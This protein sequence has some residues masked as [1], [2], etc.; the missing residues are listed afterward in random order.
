MPASQMVRIPTPLIPAVKELSSLYRSSAPEL[1]D[2]LQVFIDALKSDS[3][4]ISAPMTLEAKIAQVV[5]ALTAEA[6]ANLN[7]V[8]AELSLKIDQLSSDIDNR[9]EQPPKQLVE[10]SSPGQPDQTE[11]QL[12]R[13]DANDTPTEDVVVAES[14]ALSGVSSEVISDAPSSVLSEVI[15]DALSG[16]TDEHYPNGTHSDDIGLHSNESTPSHSSDLQSLSID[17]VVRSLP[18]VGSPSQSEPDSE[19]LQPAPEFTMAVNVSTGA[20]ANQVNPQ[21]IADNGETTVFPTSSRLPSTANSP[22]GG[23]GVT[24]I[25]SIE[26]GLP[27]LMVQPETLI[28]QPTGEGQGV[29][30]P[31]QTAT[32]TP[33]PPFNN[34]AQLVVPG[35][36][37]ST[38]VSELV[39]EKSIKWD[40]K[41]LG[42]QIA[43]TTINED[44]I[45][46]VSEEC[47][48][49][50][51]TQVSSVSSEISDGAPTV[52]SSTPPSSEAQAIQHDLL[53]TSDI[54]SSIVNPLERQDLTPKQLAVLLRVTPRTINFEA[55]NGNQSFC[56]WSTKQGQGTYDFEVMNPGEPRLNRKFFKLP[57]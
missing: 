15:S 17:E 41:E 24:E 10:L 29:A 14:D 13:P 54:V 49:L 38:Q 23:G 8:V 11:R 4:V 55:S 45:A 28:Q 31:A 21:P 6:I 25:V 46:E 37:P 52:V 12:P 7:S 39:P 44:V 33:P 9:I 42:N 5:D 16:T 35:G 22:Q 43:V 1:L 2:K 20:I 53:S 57:G 3:S 50:E 51:H 48:I 56:K 40:R 32:T 30:V 36:E 19:S 47:P 27:D 18:P 34:E 26:Q